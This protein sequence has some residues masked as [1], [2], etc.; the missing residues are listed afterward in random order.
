MLLSSNSNK[1]LLGQE[2]K[3]LSGKFIFFS[4]Y[5]TKSQGSQECSNMLFSK[6]S[7]VCKSLFFFNGYI[8]FSNSSIY[9][10]VLFLRVLCSLLPFVS[11]WSVIYLFDFL[12]PIYLVAL[13]SLIL[14]NRRRVTVTIS[15][16]SF[17]ADSLLALSQ[18][19]DL[20]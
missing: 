11:F 17:T 10:G 8:N 15:L 4:D 9:T 20:V 2:L 3:L 19:Q 13:S 14:K 12:F 16:C 6:R 5:D 18:R 7:F 1:Y